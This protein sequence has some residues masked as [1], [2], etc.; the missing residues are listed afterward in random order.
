MLSILEEDCLESVNRRWRRDS[1][2][3]WHLLER[4]WSAKVS[5]EPL[6][7][8]QYEETRAACICNRNCWSVERSPTARRSEWTKNSDRNKKPS[9][10]ERQTFYSFSLSTSPRTGLIA[11]D[12]CIRLFIFFSHTAKSCHSQWEFLMRIP[13][14][15]VAD[16]AD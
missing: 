6:H 12:L 3:V 10:E 13:T 1:L 5:T 11:F 4:D 2:K 14:N 7:R 8:R 9:S 16:Q 15:K